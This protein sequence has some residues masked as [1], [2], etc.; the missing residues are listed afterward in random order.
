MWLADRLLRHDKAS[1]RRPHDWAQDLQTLRSLFS[2]INEER[3]LSVAPKGQ[4]YREWVQRWSKHHSDASGND[5]MRFHEPNPPVGDPDEKL[6]CKHQI[7]LA[8]RPCRLLRGT[9]IV[10]E[11]SVYQ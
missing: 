2:T 1:Q 11:H 7:C 3:V 6:L 5:I 9:L 4:K 10:K 8:R